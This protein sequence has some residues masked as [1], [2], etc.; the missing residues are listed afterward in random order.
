MKPAL[1]AA[2]VA[3]ALLAAC[4]R[5]APTNAPA[6]NVAE[7]DAEANA[8]WTNGMAK[9][10]ASLPPRS[11]TYDLFQRASSDAW[12]GIPSTTG[13]ADV[14]TRL[15]SARDAALV[16]S[17]DFGQI[18]CGTAT[19]ER[20]CKGGR[21]LLLIV[22]PEALPAARTLGDNDTPVELRINGRFALRNSSAQF[23][24]GISVR[25]DVNLL[26]SQLDGFQILIDNREHPDLRGQLRQCRTIELRV[27][28]HGFHFTCDHLPDDI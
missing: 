1:A 16:T 11:V 15:T 18:W 14:T 22:R 24:P 4:N 25:G 6:D 2:L 17:Q 27:L 3:G 21:T 26:P 8:V 7:A 5:P 28:G 10:L 13:R 19:P 23:G 20:E 9:Y 12:T